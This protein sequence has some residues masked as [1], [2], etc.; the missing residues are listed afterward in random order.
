M[1]ETITN[2]H[3]ALTNTINARSKPDWTFEDEHSQNF[4]LLVAGV[5]EVGRGALAGPVVAAA[6]VFPPDLNRAEPWIGHIKDSKKLNSASRVELSEIITNKCY[7]GFGEVSPH[8]IDAINIRQAT[9]LAMR[10][11]VN[12]LH[13]EPDRAIIDGIDCIGLSIEE[14]SIIGGDS[15]S[16]TIAAASIVAKVRRDIILTELDTHFGGYGFA[17]HVG[18]GTR[19]HIKAINELGPCVVHRF[20]FKPIKNALTRV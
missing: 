10:K 6:V 16:V 12:N 8:V 7:V 14:L 13:I 19:Q 17:K 15:R 3:S 20:S 9:L 1:S 11:A 5:D 18:Y 4:P 2:N